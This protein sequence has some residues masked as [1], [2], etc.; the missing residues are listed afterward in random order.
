MPKKSPKKKVKQPKSKAKRTFPPPKRGK[1]D[2]VHP[3]P[4][5]SLIQVR[6]H[7]FFS[8]LVCLA[9]HERHL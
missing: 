1:D 9:A 2:F 4:A 5:S 6:T 3:D 8:Q 7:E